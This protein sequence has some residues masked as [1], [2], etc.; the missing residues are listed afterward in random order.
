MF[1]TWSDGDSESDS[2]EESAKLVT[3]LS[4]VCNS[5]NDSSDEEVA[6][7]ELADSYKK[8]CIRSAEV[9]QQNEK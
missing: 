8:L 4:G 2:E 9:C 7:E 3:S 5:D 1:V 6:F